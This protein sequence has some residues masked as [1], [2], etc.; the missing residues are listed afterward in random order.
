MGIEAMIAMIDDEEKLIEEIKEE[1]GKQDA[2]MSSDP[3][4]RGV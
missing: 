3:P 1:R 2:V 4:A